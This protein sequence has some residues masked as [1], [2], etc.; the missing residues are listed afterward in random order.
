M[1]YDVE[2]NN[3]E[4]S[5]TLSFLP[6]FKRVHEVH[7]CDEYI[8]CNCQYRKRYEIDC[9]HIYHIVSK[10]THFEEP[11]HHHVSVQLWNIYYKNAC[12]TFN[13]KQFDALD[14]AMKI[15]IFKEKDGFV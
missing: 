11:N 5:E 9:P 14:K 10:G 7:F 8:C 6:R 15:S 13:H 4:E 12:T 3:H 1:T 2:N